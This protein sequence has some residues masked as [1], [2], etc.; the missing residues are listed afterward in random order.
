MYGICEYSTVGYRTVHPW[1][2]R[3][4]PLVITDEQKEEANLPFDANN[5]YYNTKSCIPI[6]S[7]S[8]SAQRM[9]DVRGMIMTRRDN[10]D[11]SSTT[12]RMKQVIQHVANELPTVTQNDFLVW[13]PYNVVAFSCIPAVIRP[14]TT[15]IMEASWQTYI[16]LRAHDYDEDYFSTTTT[17]TS[18]AASNSSIK[19]QPAS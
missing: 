16:S 3:C 4:F 10:F 1:L 6:S 18:T 14:T 13:L 5:N 8:S 17:T 7:D 11:G 12:T 9:I 15:A 19:E 2:L